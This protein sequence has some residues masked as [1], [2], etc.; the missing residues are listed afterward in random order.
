MLKQKIEDDL[1]AAMLSGDS[2]RV[3][4]LK[5]LKS[6]LLYKE[7][8]LGNRD[9]GITDEQAIDVLSKEAKKRQDAAKMYTEA[10][11]TEQA[12][13]EQTEYDLIQTYLPEQMSDEELSGIVA[14]AIAD[15][16]ASS[17][18]DMGKV[19]GS[20]KAKVGAGADGAR[21]AKLVKESLS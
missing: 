15:T 9:S 8:E 19:I 12:A 18:Q 10:D 17:M 6:A 2:E 20:V 16:G 3:G 21:I 4:A 14:A 7:V 1:K 11:R 5:M 13:Q